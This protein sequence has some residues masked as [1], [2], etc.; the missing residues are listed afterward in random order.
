MSSRSRAA[1]TG[2]MSSPAAAHV[3]LTLLTRAWAGNLADMRGAKQAVLLGLL[4]AGCSGLAYLAG[5][6]AVALLRL[7]AMR[8][9]IGTAKGGFYA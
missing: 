2:A 6:L 3:F 4:V 9:L 1:T 7:V 5:A 8:L